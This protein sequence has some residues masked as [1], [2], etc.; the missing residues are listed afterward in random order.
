MRDVNF[1]G[2]KPSTAKQGECALLENGGIH[3]V[4][5]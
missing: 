1:T 3:L 5:V 4:P 2:T